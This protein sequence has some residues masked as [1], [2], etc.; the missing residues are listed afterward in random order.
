MSP[1]PTLYSSMPHAFFFPA[2]QD[3]LI[4]PVSQHAPTYSVVKTIFL[5]HCSDQLP[6]SFYPCKFYPRIMNFNFLQ[7]SFYSAL[8]LIKL[9]LFLSLWQQS[10]MHRG[11]L[12]WIKISK[13]C[14]F[15]TLGGRWQGVYYQYRFRQ[16]L[17]VN[18][19][20]SLQNTVLS[21]YKLNISFT[22]LGPQAWVKWLF[23]A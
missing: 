11:H 7:N 19:F 21:T 4:S 22:I 23:S 5:T 2:A 18:S 1:I 13:L 9:L 3:I 6:L 8:F 20:A 16:D 17:W 15:T 14:L 12:D 10:W